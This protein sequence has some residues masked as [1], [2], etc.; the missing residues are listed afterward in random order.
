VDH[1]SGVDVGLPGARPRRARGEGHGGGRG[2]GRWV[3]VGNGEISLVGASS[4][5]SRNM[6]YASMGHHI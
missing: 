1:D 3:L 2:R 6:G 4:L 5:E